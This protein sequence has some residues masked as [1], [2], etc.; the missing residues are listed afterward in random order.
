[1]GQASAGRK[2]AL[3]Y[4]IFKT[5][6]N[7]YLHRHAGGDQRPTFH[8]IDTV[9]PALNALTRHWAEIRAEFD[10]VAG[11]EMPRYHDIDPGEAAIS[12]GGDPSRRWSVYMLHLL[13]HRIEENR[14]RCPVTSR[15]I[16]GVPHLVQAF[17]SI[18]DPHKSV[19]LHEG[20]YL[21]YLRYHLGLRVPAVKPP[22][23]VVAGQ[24]HVWR[25]GTA[26]LFDDSWPH[27]VINESDGARAVL[28]VDILRPLPPVPHA[29]NRFVTGVV[30]RHTYGRSVARRV[31]AAGA[32]G[33]VV[34]ETTR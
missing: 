12:A 3:D 23:I 14:A 7:D 27:Q 22:K 19:P 33:N 28:I 32:G 26:C 21:G 20:P 34:P 25:E 30:A 11:T 5:A 18:L 16:D 2:K 8:D 13:G 4:H 6:V 10:G 29:V 17:F 24:E 31:R 1:M 9:C 15:L